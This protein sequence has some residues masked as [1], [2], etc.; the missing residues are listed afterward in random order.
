MRTIRKTEG[1]NSKPDNSKSYETPK[2]TEVS[3]VLNEAYVTPK[4]KVFG[5]VGALTQN[6]SMG[7]PEGGPGMSPT[8][9]Q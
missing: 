4:L 8:M 5:P 2:L 6:G 7:A 3:P 9:M 1:S